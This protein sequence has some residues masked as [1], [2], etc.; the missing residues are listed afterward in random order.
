MACAALAC[1]TAVSACG[2]GGGPQSVAPTASS[3]AERVASAKT[4]D[5]KD[6]CGRLSDLTTA[7]AEVGVVTQLGQVR[8]RLASATALADQATTAGT[9]PGSNTYP[10]L[11][12]L[13][14]DLRVVNVWVQAGATQSDI[15]HNRQPGNVKRYF[16]DMGVRFRDLEAWTGDN[17]KAFGGG[18]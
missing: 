12:A 11:L 13:D 1:A 6:F 10:T 14:K 7:T 8:S 18:D 15:D 16:V 5:L 4:A 3:P 17:C 2:G 9:A